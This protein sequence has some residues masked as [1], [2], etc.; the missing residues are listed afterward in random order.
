[1]ESQRKKPPAA[2]MGRRRG[3]RNRS[4]GTVREIFAA[5]VQHNAQQAQELF[6]RV[7]KKNPAMALSL[8][9]KLAE[10]V[11]PRLSRAEV[12]LPPDLLPRLSGDP[13]RDAQSA[14][15]AY[16]LVIGQPMADL[17][18]LVFEPPVNAPLAA[19]DIAQQAIETEPEP[20]YSPASQPDIQVQPAPADGNVIQLWDRLS[21]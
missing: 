17:D 10:F 21:R 7:A 18:A 16:L 6:D 2:G 3:V 19:E 12:T 15:S 13:I 4:S 8:L 1:M 20:P 5:F 11:L 9:A 14:A